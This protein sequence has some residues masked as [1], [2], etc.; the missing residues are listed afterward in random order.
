MRR[1][2]L[3][4]ALLGSLLVTAIPAE[5]NVSDSYQFVSRGSVANAVFSTLP[6][7]GP[8]PD[9]VYTDT[10][11]YAAKEATMADGTHYRDN[12]AFVSQF[13]F[14]LNSD[15]VF[16]AIAQAS[17]LVHG[18]GVSFAI[19]GG[20]TMATVSASV[21]M[22]R[23]EI[24]SDGAQNCAD[25]AST[26]LNVRWTGQGT[27]TRGMSITNWRSGPSRYI[28]RGSGSFRDAS[29]TGTLGS[30]DLGASH[31]ATLT[32]SSSMSVGICHGC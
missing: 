12:V 30:D 2:C 8:R 1:L 14:K 3:F 22:T 28:S 20:L 10:S 32:D 26:A 7:D 9:T 25:A 27:L 31:F 29:A 17:G 5:A 4:S 21:P 15:G 18:A 23:C 11:V 16:V 13:S 6:S 19:S 24:S